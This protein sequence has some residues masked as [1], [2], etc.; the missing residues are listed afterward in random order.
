MPSATIDGCRIDASIVYEWRAQSCV[1]ITRYRAGTAFPSLL[2]A[3]PSTHSS[4]GWTAELDDLIGL[5]Q[6]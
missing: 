6:P 2:T 4:D 1:V 5:F 3:F